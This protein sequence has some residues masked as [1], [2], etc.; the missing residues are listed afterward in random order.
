MTQKLLPYWLKGG[1]TLDSKFLPAANQIKARTCWGNQT[2]K[3]TARWRESRAVIQSTY[4]A[5]TCNSAA[6][7]KTETSKIQR[8]KGVGL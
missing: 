1:G 2:V 5:C 8:R 3:D 4:F 6:S 7:M